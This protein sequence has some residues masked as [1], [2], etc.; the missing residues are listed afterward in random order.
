MMRR[1]ATTEVVLDGHAGASGWTTTLSD[2][3]FNLVIDPSSDIA[4]QTR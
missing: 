4:S 2:L 3:R 1:V